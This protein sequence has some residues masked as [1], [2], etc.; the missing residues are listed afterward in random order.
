MNASQ[1]ITDVIGDSFP[2]IINDNWG[3][4]HKQKPQDSGKEKYAILTNLQKN[5]VRGC[6]TAELLSLICEG[7]TFCPAA[8]EVVEK[9]GKP[10][11]NADGWREQRLFL[12]DIDND[13]PN[14]DKEVG[15]KIK[16]PEA[17]YIPFAQALE[18]CCNNGINLAFAYK[19]FS[20]KPDFE[21]YRL[22]VLLDEVIS[23]PE[24][25]LQIVS[26]FIGLFG[27][28]ADKS[29]KNADRMFYGS[30]ADCIMIDAT[31]Q[32]TPKSVFLELYQKQNIPVTAP[33]S[34]PL[35]F[36]PS[37][38]SAP[39]ST[40]APSDFDAKPDKL[41]QMIDPNT[42]QYDEWLS[43]TASYKA[44]GG[45][46]E[47]WMAWSAAYHNA[48]ARTDAQAWKGLTGDK[49]TVGTLKRFAKEHSPSLYDDYMQDLA[50]EQNMAIEAAKSAKKK[51][52]QAP[53]DDKKKRN[54]VLD[55]DLF[56][57]WITQKYNFSFDIVTHETHFGGL[58]G[59]GHALFTETNAPTYLEQELK[60]DFDGVTIPKIERFLNVVVGENVQNP[61]L[62]RIK[63]TRWD[64][65]DRLQELF[66]ILG[67][68]ETD[69]LSKIFIYRWLMQA[70]AMLHNG[71]N[72]E[73]FSPE[74]VLVLQGRQGTGKT[75][76]FQH[77]CPAAYWGEGEMID[78]RD[79]DNLIRITSKWLCELGEVGSTMKKDVDNVKAFLTRGVDECR[80]P[81]GKKALKYP[82]KTVFVGTVN[83]TEFL[84]DPTGSRRWAVVPLNP[85][86]KIDYKTQIEPFDSWQLWSQMYHYLQEYLKQD[87]NT[88]GSSFRFT[89]DELKAL[90]QRNAAHSKP[91]KGEIEVLDVLAEQSIE[92]SG[93][94]V[95]WQEMTVTEFKEHNPALS[96]YSAA[97][98]AK[99]LEKHGYTQ[100]VVKRGSSTAKVRTLPYKTYSQWKQAQ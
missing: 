39:S 27:K 10:S 98:I 46:Y 28:A 29:C 26:A 47:V 2:V 70:I 52:P 12:V 22:A 37:P 16:L 8:F 32:T 58:E 82:R 51:Q 49:H 78:P 71:E 93:Y 1:I 13:M 19:S 92:E 36:S 38:L 43:V 9:D 96:R 45:S 74:F 42:L 6:T 4:N 68:D 95:E 72:G 80:P 60:N 65:R 55:L 77:L 86:L 23:D 83:E 73:Q 30:T 11:H 20:Y 25:R 89:S 91:M 81:Y 17:E 69:R 7:R 76:L 15:G 90:E 87:G 94:V 40:Y 59:R 21:K 48:N 66:D 63:A 75:R 35:N 57:E 61:L 33:Q 54:P 18:L 14:P 88:I 64:G 5:G 67:I 34:T 97:E 56:R 50:A 3:A 84:I 62:D 24:E 100:K 85:A 44:A 31:N 41:L 79:K 53:L 99:V